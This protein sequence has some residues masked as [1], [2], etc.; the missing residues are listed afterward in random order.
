MFS[1]R[2]KAIFHLIISTGMR[3]SEVCNLRRNKYIDL[4]ERKIFVNVT[5]TK[6]PHY[7][8]FSRPA[9]Y[10]LKL[11][12]LHDQHSSSEYLFHK[13]GSEE[14]LAIVDVY[15]LIRRIFKTTFYKWDKP[16][17]PHVLRHTFAMD[18]LKNSGDLKGLQ[19]IM[20]WTSLDMTEV[21]SRQTD[22]LLDES[23][24]KYENNKIKK[25]DYYPDIM[26][27]IKEVNKKKLVNKNTNNLLTYDKEEI[28]HG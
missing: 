26:K 19:W 24:E 21:Y 12:Y 27:K 7:V 13:E 9:Q 16:L 11:Y 5:K 8:K 2:D 4:E 3:C 17:G 28:G 18:W 15:V 6:R 22:Y 25:N 1:V 10:Y 14:P 20:G 23:Y